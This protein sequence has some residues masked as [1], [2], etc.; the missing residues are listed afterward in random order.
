MEQLEFIS[1]GKAVALLLEWEDRMARH[2]EAKIK[3]LGE[4]LANDYYANR[5]SEDEGIFPYL[6]RKQIEQENANG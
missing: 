5:K 6:A 4:E 2:R 3:A 1:S